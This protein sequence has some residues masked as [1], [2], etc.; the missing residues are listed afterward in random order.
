VKDIKTT[1]RINDIEYVHTMGGKEALLSLVAWASEAIENRDL[2][3]AL[4]VL[5]DAKELIKDI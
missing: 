3:T 1:F 4:T 2:N 5:R